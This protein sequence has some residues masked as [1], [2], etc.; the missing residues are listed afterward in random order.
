MG[1]DGFWQWDKE[2][3]EVDLDTTFASM[4]TAPGEEEGDPYSVVLEKV[5]ARVTSDALLTPAQLLNPA[6]GDRDRILQAACQEAYK[7]A[8]SAASRGLPALPG[9]PDRIAEMVVEDM[10][11]WGPL[12]DYMEDDRVEEIGSCQ[13][14]VQ[15]D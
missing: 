7:Y 13:N 6:V 4:A 14:L 3:A 5:R 12:A 1:V 10:V 8:S 2:E 15:G 11:G 9:E